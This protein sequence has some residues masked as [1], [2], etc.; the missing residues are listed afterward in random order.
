MNGSKRTA[1]REQQRVSRWAQVKVL[2]A[3]KSRRM[4]SWGR[5]WKEVGFISAPGLKT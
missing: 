5:P 4:D 2:D 1:V 3:G